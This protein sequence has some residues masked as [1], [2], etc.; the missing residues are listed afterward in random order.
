MYPYRDFVEGGGLMAY[1]PDL[2]ELARQ[3]ADQVRQLLGGAK[4]SDIPIYQPTTF[5]LIVNLKP[6]QAI[7]LTV[8]QLLLAQADEVIE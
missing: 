2:A 6:A 4:P 7:G 5:K 1:A 3:L 8:P